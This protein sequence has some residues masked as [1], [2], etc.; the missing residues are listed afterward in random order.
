M[1]HDVFISYSQP[2]RDCAW[3]ILTRLERD[4]I[5]CWIAPRDIAPS[6]DWAAAI[7]DAIA[8]ARVMILVFSASSNQSPQVR[9]EVERAVHKELSILPFRI[10]DVPPSRSLEFFLSTQHWM[11][12]FPPPR[13]RYYTRLC[14]H[15]KA[16]LTVT[17]ARIPH[18]AN[19]AAAVPRPN[20]FD[21]AELQ[22]IERQLAGFIGPL[23]GHLVK[24]TASRAAGVTDLVGRLAM[25][26]DTEWER[27]EFTRQCQ[28]ARPRA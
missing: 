2:D 25:E 23:A 6:A 7:M 12:A 10:E 28:T 18:Q 22:H 4:G 5:K 21:A 15:L 8:S 27:R 14:T 16:Q 3:E 20:Q 19:S 1:A 26:L 9:R 24:T 17:R 13:E 11:D